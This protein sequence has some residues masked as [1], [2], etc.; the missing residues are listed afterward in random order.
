MHVVFPSPQVWLLEINK[1]PTMEPSTTITERLCREVQEDTL[2][3]MIDRGAT[4]PASLDDGASSA[5]Q[6]N[7]CEDSP[8]GKWNCIVA[9]T[10]PVPK[11]NIFPAD[12]LI[13]RGYEL[14]GVDG[15]HLGSSC[16]GKLANSPTIWNPNSWSPVYT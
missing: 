12:K 1:S 5:V 15:L 4:P 6:S 10:I 8:T 11:P 3:V 16:N 7:N 9:D 13:C 2:K 14:P